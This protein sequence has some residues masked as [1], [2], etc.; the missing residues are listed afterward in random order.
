MSFGEA[1]GRRRWL[2]VA[3]FACL[4]AGS[5]GTMGARRRHGDPA[6]DAE[7]DARGARANGSLTAVDPVSGPDGAPAFRL[8]YEFLDI[9]GAKH[10]GT[11][12]LTDPKAVKLLER[13]G[14]V[15]IRYL[16]SRPDV[17]KLE[18]TRR[19]T[20]PAA[21]ANGLVAAAVLGLAMIALALAGAVR[22]IWRVRA[23]AG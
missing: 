16:A 17:H 8:A 11:A 2:L 15:T 7:L 20:L 13:Q 14:V 6:D 21:L 19:S 9:P 5:L 10:A 18:G 22:E 3:G 4:L 23:H 1:L 12:V